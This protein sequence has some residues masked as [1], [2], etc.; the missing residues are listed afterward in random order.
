MVPPNRM[1]VWVSRLAAQVAV[2]WVVVGVAVA[3]RRGRPWAGIA[4]HLIVLGLGLLLFEGCR[5]V[6]DRYRPGGPLVHPIPNSFPSGHVANAVLCIVTV[7]HLV[8]PQRGRDPLRAVAFAAGTLFV[9]AVAF[10]RI[11]F[12]LH[13][14]SDVVASLLFGLVFAAVF[15]ARRDGILRAPALALLVLVLL[16]GAAAC[17]VRV[18]LP[19][20]P[21]QRRHTGHGLR[22]AAS[23]ETRAERAPIAPARTPTSNRT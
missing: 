13:W 8:A 20:P 2:G 18:F 4:Q 3:R 22:S 11:Y 7:A 17:D 21:T 19:S 16:Y 12:A 15:E 14:F 10:T 1:A 6:L 5:L 23:P 9:G